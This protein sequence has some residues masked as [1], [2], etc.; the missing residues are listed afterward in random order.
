[1]DA[2]GMTEFTS[3]NNLVLNPG[4]TA[5]ICR[6]QDASVRIGHSGSTDKT[7]SSKPKKEQTVSS[8]TSW[9]QTGP[10][11]AKEINGSGTRKG[12]SKISNQTKKT[13][14]SWSQ[15]DT[16]MATKTTELLGMKIQ[17]DLKWDSHVLDLRKTLKKRIGVLTRLKH[18]V[19]KESLK[20]AAEA[21]FTSKIRYGIATYLRPKLQ[22][23]DESNHI[24][25]E[26]TTL[27]NDMLRVITGKKLSDHE[28]IANLRR[29]TGTMSVTQICVY[30]IMLE[31]YGI[32]NLNSS[33]V[34]KK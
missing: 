30:H 15:V 18:L 24:L 17:G 28:S 32:V 13:K 14:E 12:E 21:I 27:Q 3:S 7:I 8:S 4:K 10:E 2:E 11:G 22:A 23:E 1:M 20:M 16:V 6:G 25:K 33:P 19:P 26:L 34:L 5:L 9:T 31:T 29:T